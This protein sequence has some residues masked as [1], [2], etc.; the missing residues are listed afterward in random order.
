M[1]GLD[2]IEGDYAVRDMK[3]FLERFPIYMRKNNLTQQQKS[4][5]K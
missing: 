5:L 2:S 4:R 1:A 3:K